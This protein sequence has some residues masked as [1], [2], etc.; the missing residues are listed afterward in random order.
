MEQPRKENEQSIRSL[1]DMGTKGY[2][3]LF[4]PEWIQEIFHENQTKGPKLTS[5][6][7]NKA[8]SIMQD[9][10]KHNTLER[11]KI[12]LHAME[13]QERKVFVKAFMKMVEGKIL[14][15]KVGLQ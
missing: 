5:A 2:F 6:E 10:V 9:L 8:K 4:Q 11:K 12:V 14:D 1:I 13:E 7:K 3:P 15:E